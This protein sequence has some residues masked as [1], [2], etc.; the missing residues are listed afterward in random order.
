MKNGSC[1]FDVAEMTG[2]VIDAFFASGTTE[3]PIDGAESRVVQALFSRTLSLLIL[4]A[5]RK[6]KSQYQ[7]QMTV[8]GYVSGVGRN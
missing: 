6:K 2:T 8:K 5:R 1:Q 4:F 7:M 3:V